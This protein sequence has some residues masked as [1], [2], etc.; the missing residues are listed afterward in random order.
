MLT[1]ILPGSTAAKSFTWISERDGWKRVY[2]VSRSGDSV[3]PITPAGIDVIDMAGIDEKGGWLYYY[4][5]FAGP[6]HAETPI[7]RPT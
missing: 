3:K 5:R 2:S 4:V 7:P 1:R 6:C